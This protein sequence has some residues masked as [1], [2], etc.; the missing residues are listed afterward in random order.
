MA[1]VSLSKESFA[2]T[3]EKTIKGK[4]KNKITN[5]VFIILFEETVNRINICRFILV[6]KSALF[7]LYKVF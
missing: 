5:I 4:P 1:F 2:S 7:F 6:D 3:W